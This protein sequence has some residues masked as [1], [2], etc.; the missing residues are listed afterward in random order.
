M[1]ESSALARLISTTELRLKE[2]MRLHASETEGNVD[3]LPPP[4]T[5][6][7][8]EIRD[9]RC[10]ANDAVR[11]AIEADDARRIRRV[12]LRKLFASKLFC[13]ASCH[14]YKRAIQQKKEVEFVVIYELGRPQRWTG[15]GQGY[16]SK[17]SREPV[18]T[19]R[20]VVVR[21]VRVWLQVGGG[22]DC[23]V[24][25]FVEGDVVPTQY[26]CAAFS[27]DG[28]D[29]G[30]DDDDDND[31]ADDDN[32]EEEL[33][34]PLLL[35]DGPLGAAAEKDRADQ[36]FARMMALRH[37]AALRA[38]EDKM[39]DRLAALLA[40]LRGQAVAEELAA[41][42]GFAFWPHS[43]FHGTTNAL[44][45]DDGGRYFLR[46]NTLPKKF[47]IDY[48]LER[49]IDSDDDDEEEDENDD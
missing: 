45:T 18:L 40:G 17:D 12:V 9:A 25:C 39:T 44:E 33:L 47:A 46:A 15:A 3:M 21:G 32:D 42:R 35:Q 20:G 49:K 24:L 1:A 38:S 48:I 4:Q 11:K 14:A 6:T 13:F 41:E 8:R 27:G 28:G 22:E 7:P 10:S 16:V 43:M 19:K 36:E 2:L 23:C 5:M 31:D 34:V 30:G 29:G 26:I 37:L